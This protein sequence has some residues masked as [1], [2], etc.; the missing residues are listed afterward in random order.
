MAETPK[1]IYDYDMTTWLRC[2]ETEVEKPLEGKMTGMC[3]FILIKLF[4]SI[5]LFSELKPS[6]VFILTYIFF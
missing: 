4:N 1:K 6:L 3:Y 2:C 5:I